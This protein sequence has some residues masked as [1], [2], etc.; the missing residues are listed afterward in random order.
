MRNQ[1][2]PLEMTVQS[3][4]IS[5]IRTGLVTKQVTDALPLQQEEEG[6]E[7]D[8]FGKKLTQLQWK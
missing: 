2:A 3:H 7:T 5:R 1:P 4:S 8:V 6:G